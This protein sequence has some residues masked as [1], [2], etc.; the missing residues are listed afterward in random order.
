MELIRVIND[1]WDIEII[2]LIKQGLS[3]KKIAEQL[4]FTLAYV[5]NLRIALEES[6]RVLE[7][8]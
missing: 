5:T 3:D 8:V 6:S 1:P 4:P 7:G 2:R